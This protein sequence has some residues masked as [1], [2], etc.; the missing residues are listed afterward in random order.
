MCRCVWAAKFDRRNAPNPSCTQGPRLKCTHASHI[1]LAYL[2]LLPIISGSSTLFL[3]SYGTLI[4]MPV[5][6]LSSASSAAAAA[7]AAAL[8]QPPRAAAV[9]L[10][11]QART[12]LA[13]HPVAGDLIAAAKSACVHSLTIGY[14]MA[15]ILMCVSLRP[16]MPAASPYGLPSSALSSASSLRAGAEPPAV[17]WRP[18]LAMAARMCAGTGLMFGVWAYGDRVLRRRGVTDSTHRQVLT[19]GAAGGLVGAIPAALH[20]LHAA[21]HPAVCLQAGTVPK[22]KAGLLDTLSAWQ[23][24]AAQYR[25]AVAHSARTAGPMTSL[26]IRHLQSAMPTLRPSK[27][28]VPALH[29]TVSLGAAACLGA[30]LFPAARHCLLVDP[31]GDFSRSR[32]PEEDAPRT[33]R[34]LAQPGEHGGQQDSGHT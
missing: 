32:R 33:E 30:M 25:R 10:Q 13:V 34:T 27:V 19:V 24:H 16:Y 26:I 8:E 2:Q 9:A 22:H 29:T 7:P 15:S 4:L 11:A 3:A 6:G 17:P 20:D 14:P 1:F 28:P 23:P 12:E 5:F 18:I 31:T 21:K